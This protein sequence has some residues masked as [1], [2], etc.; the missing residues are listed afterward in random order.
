MRAT[1]DVMKDRRER[2]E[3]RGYG[4]ILVFFEDIIGMSDSADTRVTKAAAIIG[5]SV[6]S[7]D[8]S[9]EGVVGLTCREEYV[10]SS[11]DRDD[12]RV[13][14]ET[15]SVGWIGNE[16]ARAKGNSMQKRT[17]WESMHRSGRNTIPIFQT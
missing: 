9:G 16:G 11:E 12:L 2:K 15:E 3:K 14:V 7:C 6:R 17:S 5:S 4:Y 13:P 10:E 1:N 8:E